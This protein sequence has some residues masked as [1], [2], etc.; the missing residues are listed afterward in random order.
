MMSDATLARMGR[1]LAGTAGSI[2]ISSALN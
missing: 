2:D 1:V